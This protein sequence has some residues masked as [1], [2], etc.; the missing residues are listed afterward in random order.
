MTSNCRIIPAVAVKYPVRGKV[1][2]MKRLQQYR[3]LP[4]YTSFAG[5][6]HQ[7]KDKKNTQGGQK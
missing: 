1:N 7:T 6:S 3:Y 4:K 2:V 5:Q